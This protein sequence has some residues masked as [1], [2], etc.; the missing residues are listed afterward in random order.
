VLLAAA[1]E[2]G[3]NREARIAENAKYAA[4]WRIQ[5]SAISAYF[6]GIKARYYHAASV[7]L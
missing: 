5:F 6:G 4:A 7:R 3:I 1:V 2:L